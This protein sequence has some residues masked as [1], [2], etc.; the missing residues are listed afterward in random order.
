MCKP[1]NQQFFS[2]NSNP[3]IIKYKLLSLPLIEDDC[4]ALSRF[5]TMVA[6]VQCV[7]SP[8]D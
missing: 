6:N 3:K 8:S 2:V 1:L 4:Q 5:I 7:F